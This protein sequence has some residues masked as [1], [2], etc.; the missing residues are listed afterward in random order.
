MYLGVQTDRVMLSWTGRLHELYIGI[1]QA[2]YPMAKSRLP[3]SDE[4]DFAGLADCDIC[5][6]DHGPA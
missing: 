1:G 6:A 4:K 5:D 3:G 2:A